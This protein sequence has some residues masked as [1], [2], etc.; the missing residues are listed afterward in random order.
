MSTLSS[1]QDGILAAVDLGSNS[2]H[3]L[4]ARTADGELQVMDRLREMVRLGAGL[5]ARNHLTNATQRRALDCLERFGQRLSAVPRGNVRVVGTN[6]LRKA[7]NAAAFIAAAEQIL[8][9]PVEVVS[10]IEEAR[11]IYLGVSHSVANTRGPRLV[12]DIGGGSTELIVGEGFEPVAMESLYMGCVGMSHQFFPQG[13]IDR[14]CLD[15][16]RTAAHLELESVAQRFRDV[17]WAQAVGASGTVRAIARVAQA[18]GWTEADITPASLKKLAKALV[19]AGHVERLS[20]KGLGAERAPVFPGGVAVLMSV[21]EA[22][23]LEQMQVADGAL[24]EGVIYDL[25]GRIVHE[26]VRERS[27]A[28]MCQRYQVD[29]AQAD[30]VERT[31]LACL[32]QVAAGWDLTDPEHARL[33]AWAARMHEIGLAIAHNQFHK[34]GAYLAEH[35]DMSGFSRDQQRVL[36]ALI[37][38]HRRKFP[39][40][41]CRALPASMVEPAM[42]LAVLLRLAALL[43]RSRTPTPLPAFT[44]QAEAARLV[45]RF[46]SGWLAEHALTQADLAQEAAFLAAGGFELDFG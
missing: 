22:L 42:R 29:R 27:V 13:V 8:R 38:A 26:D 34:H 21:F 14:E 41:E 9:H 1:D 12:V 37:R 31:A 3:L 4:V 2:F 17:G 43:H 11:L 44:L 20:L 10:G 25:L 33:L 36:A 7:R 6:T 18:Q 45:L 23:G 16:A 35:S 30:R 32:N 40:T 28:A 19:R 15:R 5:D 46:P 39:V 24:R